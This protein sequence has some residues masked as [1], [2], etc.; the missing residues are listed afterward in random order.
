MST[1]VVVFTICRSL[2][3]WMIF[4]LP[5]RDCKSLYVAGVYV[6]SCSVNEDPRKRRP[7]PPSPGLGLG[8]GGGLR[9]RVFRVRLRVRGVFV[10]GSCVFEF[11]YNFL[12]SAL[13][14][15][16]FR[17]LGLRSSFSLQ[18]PL[19]TDFTVLWKIWPIFVNRWRP[20]WIRAWY[21]WYDLAQHMLQVTY[22]KQSG[23]CWESVLKL[24][25]G[26]N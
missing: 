15:L 18:P 20:V 25:F 24:R 8:L 12:R 9:L 13:S 4:S 22:G 7:P 16:R 10:F 5:K 26:C 21:D 1:S 11:T 3:L 14:G 17:V 23:Y 2:N 19:N 6:Y